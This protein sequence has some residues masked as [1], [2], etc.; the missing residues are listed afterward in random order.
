MNHVHFGDFEILIVF[1]RTF[2]AYQNP[3]TRF[4]IGLLAYSS[5]FSPCFIIS[6]VETMTRILN[7]GTIL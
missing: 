4:Q 5:I 6:T 3:E 7:Q 1:G 2:S